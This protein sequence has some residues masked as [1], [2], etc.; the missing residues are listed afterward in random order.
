M[1]NGIVESEVIVLFRNSRPE[2]PA[3][4]AANDFVKALDNL[5]HGRSFLRIILNHIGHQGLHKFETQLRAC[6]SMSLEVMLMM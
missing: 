6:E 1:F 3:A 5:V 4:Q 2:F